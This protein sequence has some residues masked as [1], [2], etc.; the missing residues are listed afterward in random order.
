MPLPRPWASHRP[1]GLAPAPTPSRSAPR[2]ILDLPESRRK[3]RMRVARGGRRGCGVAIR[4]GGIEDAA[5]VGVVTVTV[6]VTTTATANGDTGG[7]DEAEA[8]TVDEM[9]TARGTSRIAD[10]ITRAT[11]LEALKE[12]SVDTG[13]GAE[14]GVYQGHKMSED[15]AGAQDH[16]A[17]EI[18]HFEHACHL[19]PIFGNTRYPWYQA[20]ESTF[21]PFL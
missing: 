13:T 4:M 16:P 21:P 3:P 20:L 14:T 9:Q 2:D 11:G 5:Q 6:T 17:V 19:E 15:G 18:E 12:T 1:C 10:A 8:V 7:T